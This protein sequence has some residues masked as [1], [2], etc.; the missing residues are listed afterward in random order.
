MSH[1]RTA[2]RISLHGNADSLPSRDRCEEWA[3]AREND[4][5][6]S[7]AADASKPQIAA[8]SQTPK[9]GVSPTVAGKTIT[10][11][12]TQR[13][14]STTQAI[15]IMTPV[16]R[17]AVSG[18]QDKEGHD[19]VEHDRGHTRQGPQA[20]C[21]RVTKYEVSSGMFAYQINIYWLNQMYIQKQLKPSNNLPR[22]CKCSSRKTFCSGVPGLSQQQRHDNYR[23]QRRL[24][25]A[26]ELIDAPHGAEP[27][28][29]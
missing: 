6:D 1:A 11:R 19:P 20:P 5:E 2:Q 21:V 28:G 23:G 18:K 15:F 3:S 7:T 24:H 12:S 13:P 17:L 26:G 4:R 10:Y 22:S 29:L 16:L 8:T 14:I 9:T 25:H 27:Q